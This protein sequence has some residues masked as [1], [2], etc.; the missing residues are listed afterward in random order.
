MQKKWKR[1]NH[2]NFFIKNTPF[3]CLSL[4]VEF[5]RN[6]SIKK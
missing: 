1:K 5:G 6:I 2:M 3:I 4:I